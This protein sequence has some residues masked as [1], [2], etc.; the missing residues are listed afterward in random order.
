MFSL[1]SKKNTDT[2]TDAKPA[3]GKV[4]KGV[5]VSSK[6][7]DTIVVSVSRYF[8]HPKYQKFM[9][10]DKKFQVHDPGNTCKTGD[11]VSIRES[12]PISKNKRFVVI[13]NA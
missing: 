3:K 2:T 1:K 12:K 4:L 7:K 13:N 11:K 10:V 6:M 8:K 9:T 5:V